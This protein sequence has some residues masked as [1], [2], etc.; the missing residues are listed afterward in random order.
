[1][2]K[3][4]LAITGCANAYLSGAYNSQISSIAVQNAINAI[5]PPAG[6]TGATGAAGGLA[7]GT[8]SIDGNVPGLGRFYFDGNANIMGLA[9]NSTTGAPVFAQAGIYSAASNCTAAIAMSSGQHSNPVVAD[10]GNQIFFIQSDASGNGAT[11]VPQRSSNSCVG[12]LYPQ[13][14]GFQFSGAIPIT[15]SA[16]TGATDTTTTVASRPSPRSEF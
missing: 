13:S 1:M 5:N 11:G 14:F 10:Q 3:P 2:A 9:P 12:S 16:T 4:S 8:S 6:T 7:G 15:S